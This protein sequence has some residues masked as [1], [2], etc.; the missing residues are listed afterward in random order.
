MSTP[1][2]HLNYDSNNTTLQNMNGYSNQRFIGVSHVAG[3]WSLG[4]DNKV[5]LKLPKTLKKD[6][7]QT[8]RAN[9]G[10]VKMLGE[11]IQITTS[12]VHI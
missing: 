3:L 9:G 10:D 2:N 8:L 4:M 5:M 6:I 1:T 11:C 12:S 7:L